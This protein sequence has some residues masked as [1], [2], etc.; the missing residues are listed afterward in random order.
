MRVLKFVVSVVFLAGSMGIAYAATAYMGP[1]GSYDVADARD[2]V[3]SD[4]SGIVVRSGDGECVRTRWM[5]DADECST[6]MEFSN[7]KRVRRSA[8]RV[9]KGKT[10]SLF[11]IQFDEFVAGN[12]AKAR[13]SGECSDIVRQC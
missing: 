10:H 7:G 2:V 9:R 5:S 13:H 3:H 6:H 4:E 12:A 1:S 8:C 11:R